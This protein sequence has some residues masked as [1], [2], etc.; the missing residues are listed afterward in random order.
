MKTI[1]ASSLKRYQTCP[2]SWKYNYVLKLMKPPNPNYRIGTMFHKG[3]EMLHKRGK[4][5]KID[6]VIKDIKKE[7]LKP[8]N[9]ENIDQFGLVRQMLECYAK[10][11]VKAKTVET[12]W[13]F[14]VPVPTVSVPLYGFI[15]RLTDKGL[16]EYKTSSFDYKQ[17]DIINIQ[18][19]VYSYAYRSRFGK[20]PEITYCVMNKKKVKKEGYKPQI[21]IIKRTKEDIKALEQTLKEF[22]KNVEK[23]CFNPITGT[24]CCW[25]DFRESCDKK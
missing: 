12:E 25:C 19:D 10:N 13:K 1:S 7:M 21:L 2:L 4:A 14:S 3:V 16:I 9:D 17:E 5:P 8:A 15:D 22:Y 24:H 20:L 6:K 11:Q 18:T 23:K